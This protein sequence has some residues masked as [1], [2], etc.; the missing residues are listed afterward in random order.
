MP[1]KSHIAHLSVNTNPMNGNYRTHWTQ[2]SDWGIMILFKI[3]VK[4]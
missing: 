2:N 4:K 1:I 3:D